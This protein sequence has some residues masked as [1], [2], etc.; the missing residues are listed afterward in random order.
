MAVCE[1]A[2]APPRAP[3]HAVAAGTV[4]WQLRLAAA[5]FSRL[6]FPRCPLLRPSTTVT[7]SQLCPDCGTRLTSSASGGQLCPRCLM[8]LALSGP[9]TASEL[10][11]S[12]TLPARI[13][14]YEVLGL[15][16]QGGMGVV[17]RARD[18]DLGRELAIKVLHGSLVTSTQLDRFE[19]E[20]KLLASL[21]HPNIATI[22]AIG[23]TDGRPY[24]VLELIAGQPL[25]QR[26]EAGALPLEQVLVLGKQVAAAVEAAH[27]AG[28]VHRDLKPANIMVT[29]RGLV[30]IL[31]FGIAKAVG[32]RPSAGEDQELTGA[33]MLVGTVPYMSPEQ[34]RGEAVD[35]RSDLWAF[36]CLLFESLTGRSPFER[37][38]AA[39]TFVAIHEN[40][41][42]LDELPADTPDGVRALVSEC[43]Q[44][45]PGQRSISAGAARTSLEGALGLL[46]GPARGRWSETSPAQRIAG[47]MVGVLATLLVLAVAEGSVLRALL[48]VTPRGLRGLVSNGTW[49]A[50]AASLLVGA[51]LLVARDRPA[52]ARA[53]RG[54]FLKRGALV[55]A[56]LLGFSVLYLG[57][58]WLTAKAQSLGVGALDVYVALPFEPADDEDSGELL[59]LSER[60][61]STLETVFSDVASVRIMPGAYDEETL[62]SW[63]PQ[64]TLQRVE[65]WMAGS[66]LRPDLVLCNWVNLF[67]DEGARGMKVVSTLR[68][69]HDRG[70]E[71]LDRM[72][73]QGADTEVVYLALRTGVHL[74]RSLKDEPPFEL[75]PADEQAV[76]DR[77]LD[78]YSIFL[79]LKGETGAQAARVVDDLRRSGPADGSSVQEVLDAYESAVSLDSDA[80]RHA[81]VRD[82]LLQ[83]VGGTR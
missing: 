5:T 27:E 47:A 81:R 39:L 83:R 32:V 68:R 23:E 51:A 9:A 65:L 29:E 67:V 28:I 20:A 62:G 24:L 49:L 34:I 58:S 42:D 54:P 71:F 13:G 36:G 37:R 30:K 59:D 57:G 44:K 35:E 61:R 6:F 25:S 8:G 18:P 21:N 72:N 70:L 43:L 4:W 7:D 74:V 46:Q 16:G 12:T 19:R 56:V 2:S 26:L 48:A 82:A 10:A 11:D 60:Y 66:D 14:T 64:C 41:P 31:D 69:V 3:A 77:I 38:T 52:G 53:R 50:L 75:T 80:G 78:Q 22:H 55:A 79:T 1:T 40:E 15:L 76:M 73:A 17:Y 63:P 33:G 45:E